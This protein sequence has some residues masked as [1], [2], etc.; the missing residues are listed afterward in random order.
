LGTIAKEIAAERDLSV[1]LISLG[2]S[3]REYNEK[4][5]GKQIDSKFISKLKTGLSDIIKVLPSERV[6]Q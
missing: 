2:D 6:S 4:L 1:E 3:L 5:Q